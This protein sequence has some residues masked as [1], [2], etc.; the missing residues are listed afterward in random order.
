MFVEGDVLLWERHIYDT[1]MLF[2][3]IHHILHNMYYQTE[4]KVCQKSDDTITATVEAPSS[5]VAASTS[6]SAFSALKPSSPSTSHVEG[7]GSV[8]KKNNKKT[9]QR[10]RRGSAC[11]AKTPPPSRQYKTPPP[12]T[13]TATLRPRRR[14]STPGS[15]DTEALVKAQKEWESEEGL[16]DDDD[17]KEGEVLVTIRFDGTVTKRRASLRGGSLR[18]SFKKILSSS[19]TVPSTPKTGCAP[20]KMKTRLSSSFTAAP[21][22]TLTGLNATSSSSSLLDMTTRVSRVSLESSATATPTKEICEDIQGGEDEL[23]MSK[24]EEDD[25]LVSLALLAAADNRSSSDDER[26][27][28][29]DELLAAL[30]SGITEPSPY[31]PETNPDE[32]CGDEDMLTNTMDTEDIIEDALDL[33]LSLETGSPKKKDEDT[34]QLDIEPLSKDAVGLL[35]AELDMAWD[36]SD[37]DRDKSNDTLHHIASM[38]KAGGVTRN[39]TLL[40]LPNYATPNVRPDQQLYMHIHAHLTSPADFNNPMEYIQSEDGLSRTLLDKGALCRSR[41]K[42]ILV[43]HL[44]MGWWKEDGDQ[45]DTVAVC[46]A[47][48]QQSAFDNKKVCIERLI[49]LTAVMLDL[50]TWH[51][52]KKDAQAA[53]VSS[54][55][56]AGDWQRFKEEDDILFIGQLISGLWERVSRSLLYS[57]NIALL[58]SDESNSDERNASLKSAVAKLDW[59]CR[60]HLETAP[61]ESLPANGQK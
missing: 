29:D 14:C 56:S 47:T 41:I 44:D 53:A 7:G 39:Q 15:M 1:L 45:A 2:Y 26:S 37:A 38:R 46:G 8:K 57:D 43:G 9:P 12:S 20:S 40:S 50:D 48:T 3:S 30:A 28:S 61:W 17:K 60:N 22:S 25:E 13:H 16:G 33:D 18:S 49:A 21:M 31:S 55:S 42:S 32:E 5:V 58:N 54:A 11:K 24:E 4:T 34:E 6:I 10:R 27:S 51:T 23:S 35:N 52:L 19:F 59:Y 36:M